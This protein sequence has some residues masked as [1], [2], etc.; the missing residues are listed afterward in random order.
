MEG[1]KKSRS[2]KSRS[3]RRRSRSRKTRRT[4][5]SIKRKLDRLHSRLEY[6]TEPRTKYVIWTPNVRDYYY[7]SPT[8]NNV[9]REVT[10][11]PRDINA[12]AAAKHEI[13]VG[14]SGGSRHKRRRRRNRSPRR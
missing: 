14:T 4:L 13:G 12:P 2:R 11:K 7:T 9:G 8:A 5:H 6:A 1:G 3:R 10:A